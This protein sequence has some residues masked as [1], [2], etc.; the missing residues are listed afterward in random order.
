MT[1]SVT[2]AFIIPFLALAIIPALTLKAIIFLSYSA[3]L[4]Q[5][6]LAKSPE[7]DSSLPS[8]TLSNS[9]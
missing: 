3:K 1:V 9:H 6:F 4:I 2:C 8:V 7:I 5:I